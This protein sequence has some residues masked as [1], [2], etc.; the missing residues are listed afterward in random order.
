[1]LIVACDQLELFRMEIPI[2]DS[3]PMVSPVVVCFHSLSVFFSFINLEN[4]VGSASI[5]D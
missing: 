4:H 5:H 1:M 2:V 3:I